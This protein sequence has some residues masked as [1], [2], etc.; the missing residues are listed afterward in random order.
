[1]KLDRHHLWIA[2]V[3]ATASAAFAPPA[4]AQPKPASPALIHAEDNEAVTVDSS[5]RKQYRM[6]PM[7]LYTDG[8]P[9]RVG[10]TRMPQPIVTIGFMYETSNGLVECSDMWRDTC[11]PHTYGTGVRLERH[12]IVLRRGLWWDCHGPERDAVCIA[13]VA[14]NGTKGDRSE[15]NRWK[16]PVTR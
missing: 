10:P 9:Q 14:L 12:W 16:T 3:A 4:E 5:G 13:T 8:S 11:R 7:P 6:P 15:A 1:M 2:I